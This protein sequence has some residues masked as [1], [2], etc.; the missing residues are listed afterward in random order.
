MA[1]KEILGTDDL[2][3]AA[4]WPT[5]N[6]LC[7]GVMPSINQ[8]LTSANHGAIANNG[9]NW[10]KVTG[11][12]NPGL[13]TTLSTM[14]FSQ[15]EMRGKKIWIG[16]R[17]QIG[18]NAAVLAAIPLLSIVTTGQAL[19]FNPVLETDLQ[20]AT[21]EVFIECLID[22]VAQK[23]DGYVDGNLVRS[24]STSALTPANVTD[25]RINY[26]MT[27]GAVGSEIHMYTDFYWLVDSSDVDQLPS[28]RLGPI[29]V[30]SAKVAG[31]VLPSDWTVPE[32][33]TADGILDASTMA[34]TTELTPVVRT[35]PAE[36]V[37]SI[38]FAKPAAELSIKAVSIEVFGYRDTGT[39][40]ALQAQLKQGAKTDT[41]K[42]FT[43]PTLDYNRGAVSDRLGCFNVDLNGAAW[44]NDSIDSLEVLIN[45]KTGA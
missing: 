25:M 3:I 36:S 8:G 44:N 31:S 14:K 38:G 2:P 28:N 29:K 13:T 34:P 21:D 12:A 45:S 17:H 16:F 11:N 7:K 20:R 23:I 32:G 37:A 10:I 24:I 30:K 41:K 9:R 19:T 22:L 6:L 18:S 1:I 4:R 42:T 40:P 35:S 33:Q 27:S 5:L 15:A 43:T 39:A 26:G